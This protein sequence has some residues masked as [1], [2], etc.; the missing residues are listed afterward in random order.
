M[1]AGHTGP[2]RGKRPFAPVSSLLAVNPEPVGTVGRDRGLCEACRCV[3][4]KSPEKLYVSYIAA[5]SQQGAAHFG[6]GWSV[7]LIAP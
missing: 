5:T 6:L 7:G 2:A 1:Q 3:L 4:G